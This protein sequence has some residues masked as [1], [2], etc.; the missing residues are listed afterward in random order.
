MARVRGPSRLGEADSLRK[1]V[2][3]IDDVA[4]AEAQVDEF[5]LLHPGELVAD[6]RELEYG[7][8][9]DIGQSRRDLLGRQMRVFGY[10]VEEAL[11]ALVEQH[12]AVAPRRE[13]P[14]VEV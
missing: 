6:A 1:P 5:L 4:D 2:A 3:R 10:D 12:L 13:Q 11:R 8:G 14:I 9:L 7:V